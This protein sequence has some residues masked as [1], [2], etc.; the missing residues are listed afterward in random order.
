MIP[1]GDPTHHDGVLYLDGYTTDTPYLCWLCWVCTQC[2]GGSLPHSLPHHRR[3]PTEEDDSSSTIITTPRRLLG[4][5][6]IHFLGWDGVPGC[7]PDQADASLQSDLLGWARFGVRLGGLRK[8][9]DLDADKK[10][11]I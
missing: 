11:Q 5:S 9:R 1:H 10:V 2:N 8:I 7:P 6:L 4:H 3:Y